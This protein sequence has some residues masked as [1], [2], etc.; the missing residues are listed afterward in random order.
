M[1]VATDFGPGSLTRSGYPR[2]VKE[3]KRGTPLEE[4]V[5]VFEA[6]PKT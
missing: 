6:W 1:F 2:I 4:A 5:V 3:W